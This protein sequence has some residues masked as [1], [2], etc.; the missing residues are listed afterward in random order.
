[1]HCQEEHQR[2]L[3]ASAAGGSENSTSDRLSPDQER[4]ASA[5][6]AV[7]EDPFIARLRSDAS[8]ARL[9]DEVRCDASVVRAV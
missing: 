6:Q 4:G 7:E 8:V 2:S 5:L 9:L 3:E 1:M